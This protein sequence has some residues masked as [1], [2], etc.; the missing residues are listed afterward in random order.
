MLPKMAALVKETEQ[1]VVAL[2][3]TIAAAA[4]AAVVAATRGRVPE[5]QGVESAVVLIALPDLSEESTW[6]TG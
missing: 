2:T 1:L 6:T 3:T 4:A 5:L